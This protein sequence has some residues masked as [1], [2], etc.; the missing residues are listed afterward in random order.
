VSRLRLASLVALAAAALAASGCGYRPVYG[1]Q[2]AATVG[3]GARA[4]LASVKVLGIAD[5]R[6]QLLRNYLLDRMTPRGEPAAPRYVLA[7]T[8]SE[9]TRTT[10][11]RPDGTA[12]RADIIV[13]ARYNLR[14]ATTDLLVF[15]ERSEAIATFNLLTARFASVASEDEAR[16]RAVEQLADQISVQ[17]SLFLNRRHTPARADRAQ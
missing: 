8:T 11:S 4:N 12:T 5:R 14:D 3:D 6:G 17:V 13:V 1:E 15:S 10:D 16:R 2:A 9:S 7:V